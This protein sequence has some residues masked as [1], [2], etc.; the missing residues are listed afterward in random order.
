MQVF[1]ICSQDWSFLNSFLVHENL[2]E[3]TLLT[4]GK[5]EVWSPYSAIFLMLLPPYKFKIPPDSL[6]T[7][8]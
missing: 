7:S 5:G 4:V 6:L 3:F 1:Q 8:N 2:M